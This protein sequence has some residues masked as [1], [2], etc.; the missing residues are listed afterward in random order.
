PAAAM[1]YTEARLAEAAR[2]LLEDID[3]ETVDWVDNFD[4][5]LR[6]PVVLP[7]R[8]PLAWV[9]GVSG[10]SPGIS[11]DIL[12]HNLA[13]ICR[14]TV[15]L[16]KNWARRVEVTAAELLK[17]V[18][19]PDFPTGGIVFRFRD[20]TDQALA[21]YEQGSG[22]FTLQA[23]ADIHSGDIVITEIPYGLKKGDELSRLADLMREGKVEGIS[24]VRDESSRK[25]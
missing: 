20:E 21:A 19:G 14:A 11:T 1:R 17:F 7:A 16:A 9:I 10:L 24:E 23:R 22:S 13:E 8:V 12:P 6:E 2:F 18:P 4:A 5:S 15:Y 25:G 3:E